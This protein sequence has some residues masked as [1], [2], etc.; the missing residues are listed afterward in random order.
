MGVLN[1]HTGGDGTGTSYLGSRPQAASVVLRLLHG[2]RLGC[3][4]GACVG[5]VSMST[6]FTDHSQKCPLTETL[7]PQSKKR[8]ALA[9][10]AT[11]A[12][13]SW[14]RPPTRILT[15]RKQT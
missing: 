13:P 12:K 11:D 14:P 10:R 6:T 9:R 4:A 1:R 3:C 2:A 5:R 8:W 15:L 7:V